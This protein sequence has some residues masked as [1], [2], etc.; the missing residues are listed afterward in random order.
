[1]VTFND[2]CGID[3]FMDLRWILED[4]ANSLLTHSDYFFKSCFF[5][6]QSVKRLSISDL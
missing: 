2:V 1:M 3:E 4:V 5:L 6:I